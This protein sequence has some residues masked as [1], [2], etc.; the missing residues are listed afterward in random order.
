M[1][2]YIL[3]TGG[4]GY[5]GSHT[6]VSLVEN[7]YTPII[8]DDFRNANR[9]VIEG[10]SQIIGEK[11]TIVEIDVCDDK[12]LRAVFEKYNFEGVIHFA[13]HKAVGESVLDPLKYYQNNLQGLVNVLS[14]MIEFN[15]NN[16]V[17]SSSCTVYGE[18][19]GIT[20]MTEESPKNLPN[21]PYGW[22]KWIGEQIIEDTFRANPQ[23]KLMS[24]RYFNPV[25]AHKSL[26]IGEFPIG[27]PNNLLPY[28][29]QTAIG[30]QERLTVFGNDYSTTD[31][32]CIRDYIHVVDLAFAHVKAISFLE[33]QS[34]CLEIIN[35]GT[36]KGSSVLEI[37]QAFEKET[38]Q[39]LNWVFGPRREGDVTE[40]YA[41]A[42]KAK[43]V[44]GWEAKL[45][46][47]DA[48]VDAWNWEK[49]LAGH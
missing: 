16:F 39:K 28:I 47:K 23:L 46:I 36:G 21:S 30:K 44:L 1:E 10:L 6:V 9:I 8:L 27:K 26:L 34:S 22:T 5:I 33:S 42:S 15:V 3:V 31:G 2:K 49:R 38:G 11:P 18:P 40:V 48:V 43:D 37:I 7:G 20:E 29:T 14:K 45:T 17:F 35:I 4:A 19:V 13:A 24:L 32:T 41:N 12:G 25:G